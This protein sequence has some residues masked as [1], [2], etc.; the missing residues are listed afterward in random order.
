MVI[1]AVCLLITF[2]NFKCFNSKIINNISSCVF[3]IYLIHG[4]PN[5]RNVIWSDIFVGSKFSNTYFLI[6]YMIIA[7]AII[8]LVS[9]FVEL[10]RKYTIE[11][12]N[13]KCVD[14]IVK[15]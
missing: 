2:L 3:G 14:M 12:L 4:N 9:L 6:M 1:I 15:K 7:V 11:K 8:F 13:I 10:I 5:I